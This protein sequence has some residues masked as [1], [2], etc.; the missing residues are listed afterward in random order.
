[1]TSDKT[2]HESERPSGQAQGVT[3]GFK[4]KKGFI[5]PKIKVKYKIKFWAHKRG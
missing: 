2:L 1:M 5:Y 4:K 3:G